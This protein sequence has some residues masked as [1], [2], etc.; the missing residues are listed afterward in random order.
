M[1]HW[2]KYHEWYIR[3]FHEGCIDE[4]RFCCECSEMEV[5]EEVAL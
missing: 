4:I 3:P 1:K 5:R 2:C